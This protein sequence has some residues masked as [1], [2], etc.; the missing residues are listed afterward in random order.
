MKWR[1]M[2][3]L[4]VLLVIF[5][6]L[7]AI[8][9]SPSGDEDNDG[10]PS[11]SVVPSGPEESKE[12]LEPIK[13]GSL[14]H[15]SG[16][17]AIYGV[18]EQNAIELAVDE[19]NAAG[20]VLGRQIQLIKEDDNTD[21]DLSIQKAKKLCEVDEV[22]AI[23]GGVW[24]AI[25]AAVVTQ[26]A[27]PLKVPFFYPTYNEGGSELANCSRYYVCTGAIPNQ[28]LVELIP[29]LLENFG[30]KVY[31]VGIDEVMTTESWNF[32]DEN[33]LIEDGGGT[34]VGRDITP[35]EVGDWSSVIQ[36]I[37]DSGAE[38]VI[39]YIGGVE[40]VNFVKQ[41]Y[42]FGLNKTVTLASVFLHETFITSFPEELRQGIICTATYFQTID[43]PENKT[44]L[45]AYEKKYGTIEGVS[46]IPEAAYSSVYLWK[47]AVEKAGVVDKEAMLD[48]L[49]SVSFDAPQGKM[50]VSSVNQHTAMHSYIAECQEDGTFKLLFDLGYIEPESACDLRENP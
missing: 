8:G 50:Q 25:R 39:P 43:T 26:V 48:A 6:M 3:L 44:F 32:I 47:L 41:F 9:C 24:S 4:G 40:M 18:P 29:Y 19:I 49:P 2:K 15:V 31:L 36:R 34:I 16:L 42:D 37:K 27:D 1:M 5:L 38:I 13:I 23:F 21:T 45:E 20:G 10:V 30:K 17:G 22:E 12:E 14:N 33:K 35:W 7:G 11:D 28:Q 46:N